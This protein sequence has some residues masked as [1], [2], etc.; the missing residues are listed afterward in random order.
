MKNIFYLLI[1]SL[2][3]LSCNNKK[4]NNDS[5]NH[6]SE[7]LTNTETASVSKISPPPVYIDSASST[8]KVLEHLSKRKVDIEELLKTATPEQAN[9]LYLNFYKENDS[10]IDILSRRKSKLLDQYVNFMT[11]D[12]KTG[13]NPLVIPKEHQQEIKD[14]EQRGVE[15]WYVGEGYTELRMHPDFYYKMFNGKLTPDFQRWLD[16]STK[17]NKE[18]YAADA[19][20]L[21][22]WKE[23]G[24]RIQVREQF[25][26]DFPNSRLA[27]EQIKTELNNYRWDYFRGQD[28]TP[29][30]YGNPEYNPDDMDKNAIAEFQRFIKANPNSETTK[31]L[32]TLLKNPKNEVWRE[33]VEKFLGERYYVPGVFR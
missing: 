31:M 7:R 32:Q 27:K 19:G 3:V 28:N 26:K 8:Q 22:E 1:V 9:E 11:Y 29:V 18:L 15:F 2:L 4:E 25:L 20:I 30:F 16:F 24:N 6:Q 14:I 17:E 23:I 13:N 10:A 5:L 21:V 12:E 33:Q